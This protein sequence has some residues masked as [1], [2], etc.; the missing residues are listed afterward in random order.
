MRGLRFGEASAK[1][2]FGILIPIDEPDEPIKLYWG[3]ADTVTCVGT[4]TISEL[5]GLCFIQSR[6]AFHRSS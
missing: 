6:P 4:A 5:V 1:I 2:A 3:G